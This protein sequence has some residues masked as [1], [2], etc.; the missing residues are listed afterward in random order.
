[1]S[2]T[3]TTGSIKV[4]DNYKNLRFWKNT[5]I[6]SL[7][8]GQTAVLPYGTLGNEW[9]PEQF[10]DTYPAH[11]V[12]LSNTLQSGYTHKMSLYRYTSGAL[13]FSVGMGAG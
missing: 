3:Q 4:P 2:W 11:R 12:I 5:S 9:D 10:T 8:T 6:A 7:A 13:I 1:M